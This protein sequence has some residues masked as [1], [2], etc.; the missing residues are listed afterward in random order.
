MNIQLVKLSSEYKKQL[1]EMLDEWSI[2]I[3]DNPTYHSPRIIFIYD[4]HDFDNYCNNLDILNTEYGKVP[5]STFFCLD[6]DRNIFV[7]AVSIR[8]YLNEELIQYAGHIGDGIRPSERGKGYGTAMIKLALEECKK[9]GIMDVLMCCLKDNHASA[10]TII[11]NGGILE[12]EILEDG[13]L[14]QRYWIKL[15]D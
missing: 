1:F 6:L 12:N 11:N 15:H 14:L 8:H 9:L 3:K 7:G 10:K 2:E 13:K 4:Y 5:C